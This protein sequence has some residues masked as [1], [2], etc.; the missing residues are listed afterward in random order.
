[1]DGRGGA[2]QGAVAEDKP[3]RVA[4]SYDL[5]RRVD[6]NKVSISRRSD[7]V[8]AGHLD[9]KV[10]ESMKHKLKRFT[11][12]LLLPVDK[13]RRGDCN[14]C[15]ECCRLPYPCPF[16]RYDEHG[17][18]SCLVYHLRPPSCRKY[19][20]TDAENLTSRVCGYYFANVDGPV[21]AEHST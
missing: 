4:K 1:M 20:R 12:S 13:N 9:R 3:F 21:P 16:L 18:S 19:P 10:G 11:T 6:A 15:G 17:K 7:F 14:R 2:T 8:R 5:D